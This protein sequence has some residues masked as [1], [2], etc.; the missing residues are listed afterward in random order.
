MLDTRYPP[1]RGGGGMP[2]RIVVNSRWSPALRT[3]GAGESGN[4]PGIGWRLP[5]YLFITRKSA[6]MAAWFVVIE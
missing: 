4:T 1:A 6:M 5:T 3:T 2:Q